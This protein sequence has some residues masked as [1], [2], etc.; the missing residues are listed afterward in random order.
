MWTSTEFCSCHQPN[1]LFSEVMNESMLTSVKSLVWV[2]IN[3]VM[4]L[5]D[6]GFHFRMMIIL[7]TIPHWFLLFHV[8]VPGSSRNGSGVCPY[9]WVLQKV[10]WFK[11]SIQNAGLCPAYFLGQFF[12]D[13]AFNLLG[14]L[15]YVFLVD[16]RNGLFSWPAVRNRFFLCFSCNGCQILFVSQ[17]CHLLTG[18]CSTVAKTELHLYF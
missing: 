2:W 17:C 6:W 7:G 14:N 16:S 13:P 1:S 5:I 3:W 18:K 10:F 8:W 15:C 11:Q 9:L 4:V 12:S